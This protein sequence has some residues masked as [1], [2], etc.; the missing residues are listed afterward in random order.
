[1]NRNIKTILFALLTLFA[2]NSI[3]Q[4]TLTAGDLAFV[5]INTS[6]EDD[7][8][9]FVLLVPITTSTQIQFTDKGWNE[10]TGFFDAPG[11]SIF[12]W[13]ASQNLPAGT[14]VSIIT[15]NGNAQPTP[16]TG[17]VS[18]SNM[19]ISIAGDQI[20]AFQGTPE[21]PS[22]IAAISFNQN[23][24]TQPGNKFDAAAYSNAT[25]DLPSTLTMGLNALHIYDVTDFSERFNFAYAGTPLQ[26][27]KDAIL[28][29]IN[30]MHAWTSN[31][32]TELPPLEIVFNVTIPTSIDQLQENK[33]AIY[34]NPAT[35][36]FVIKGL[37]D[38]ASVRIYDTSGKLVL[39]NKTEN[40]EPIYIQNLAAGTY[41][42][43]VNSNNSIIQHKLIVAR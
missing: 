27:S 32:T 41:L 42:V 15:H 37:V 29:G 11:D 1:M 40:N 8:F 34:P 43:E 35:G 30:D 36:F 13:T 17:T 24:T 20:F 22:F 2:T 14:I 39:I 19:L 5:G 31:N 10:G 4:T 18:G 26:G 25:T 9:E 3:A 33:V 12:T 23:G 16:S 6:G 7:R 38:K 21:S 28:Y